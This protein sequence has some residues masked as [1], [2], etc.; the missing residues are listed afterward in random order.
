MLAVLVDPNDVLIVH[1]RG[2]VGFL[3]EA[4]IKLEVPVQVAGQDF[5]GIV[6]C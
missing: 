5:D 4:L 2:H 6:A 3:V 1:A